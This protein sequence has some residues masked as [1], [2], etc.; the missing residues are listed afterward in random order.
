MATLPELPQ[1]DQQ[2]IIVSPC[3]ELQQGG[4]HYGGQGHGSLTGSQVPSNNRHRPRSAS[5]HSGASYG[6]STGAQVQAPA[7]TQPAAPQARKSP[8][9]PPIIT[10]IPAATP[11][12]VATPNP[13]STVPI[14]S[15]NPH[16]VNGSVTT[17]LD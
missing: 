3:I 2:T 15:S 14:R 13:V 5:S 7:L 11:K 8:G 10:P 17:S 1:Q 4:G 12:T 16:T 9:Q 6:V